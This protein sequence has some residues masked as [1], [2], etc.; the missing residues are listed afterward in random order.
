MDYMIKPSLPSLSSLP[1]SR[2]RFSISPTW[3]FSSLHPSS[4]NVLNLLTHA[5]TLY[6][7]SHVFR[8]RKPEYV[9]K[10]VILARLELTTFLT[11][12]LNYQNTTVI[13]VQRGF[14]TRLL[15]TPFFNVI[16]QWVAA[17]RIATPRLLCTRQRTLPWESEWV[18]TAQSVLMCSLL[19]PECCGDSTALYCMSFC[20]AESR[21]NICSFNT[22]RLADKITLCL[23]KN[24]N[25]PRPSQHPPV[26]GK[27]NVEIAKITY[28]NVVML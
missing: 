17:N 11:N 6:I 15:C 20:S 23:K 12:G 14:P 10:K 9:Q 2:L 8:Y 7:R 22:R 16:C 28:N 5:R 1:G 21:G 26:R 13:L 3:K 24:Q 19:Y 4:T 25:A 18:M 27:K